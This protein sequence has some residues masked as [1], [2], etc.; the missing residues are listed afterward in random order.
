MTIKWLNF[1]EYGYD[2]YPMQSPTPLYGYHNPADERKLKEPI[3]SPIE[4]KL[5]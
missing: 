5:L 2:K 1:A 3:K 4:K